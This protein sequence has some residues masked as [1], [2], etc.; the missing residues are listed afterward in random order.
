MLRYMNR[1]LQ[2]I[3]MIKN[4]ITKGTFKEP[5]NPSAENIQFIL[6]YSK[7]LRFLKLRRSMRQVEINLN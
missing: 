4:Y 7:S 2:S 5:K 6:N 1:I 3:H